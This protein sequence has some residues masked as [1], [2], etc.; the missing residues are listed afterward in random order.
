MKKIIVAALLS[1]LCWQQSMAQIGTWRNFLAYHDIQQIQAAGNELF[2]MA[3]NGLYQYSKKDQSI[4]TYDKVN[5][6]SSSYIVAI[7]WNQQAKRLVVVYDDSNIDLV[8]TNYNVVNISDIYAKS[9]TGG[10]QIYDITCYDNY[11]FLA[12]DFG[13]VKLNV[14]KAE[15]S[16]TYSLG[17]VVSDIAVENNVVYI[18]SASGEVF[19]GDM[20]KNLIDPSNWSTTTDHPSFDADMTDYNTNIDLV[21]TLKPGGPNHNMFGFMR[22][23]NN[24]LYTCDGTSSNNIP[25][26]VYSNNEWNI[27]QSEGISEATGVSFAGASCL[28]VDPSNDAHVFAGARNGLYEYL[29]GK[30]VKFYNNSNSPIQPFNGV[31]KE[32]QL[33]TNVKYDKAGNLWI[34]NSQAPTTSLVRYSNGTFTKLN[35]SEWMKLTDSSDKTGYTNKSNGELGNMI[36]DSQGFFWFTNNNW[37]LPALYLYD[38]QN[39]AARAYENFVNQ[40]GTKV[41][42]TYG[43]R[44]V[45]EDLD[46]NIWIGTDK[47]PL[48]LER[49]RINNNESVFTQVKVPRNDGTDLADYLLSGI[50]ILSMAIDGAGRKWFGTNGNGVYLLSSD[51]LTQIH[52]F[53]TENSN[54]LSNIVKSIAINP[55]SGEVFM[56]TEDGLCSYMSDATE[57]NAEMTKDNVW[58]YPNPVSPDYSGPITIVG[59]TLNADVKILASNGALVYEGRSNGG[60]F[61]WNGCD[62]NGNR[63]ASGV[64]MVATATSSGE[65]GTVCKIAIVR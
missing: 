34:M 29:D 31:S 11:A 13:V 20:S 9:I 33:V 3:S 54:L 28:D 1:V 65:K 46:N 59:L 64:Y 55:V 47:G 24:K 36:I 39:N 48:M 60:M 38:A 57:A 23:Q 58:A 42:V 10:K 62:R 35:H 21:K 53:T 45:A 16:E 63:V 26:Q 32:Y 2:V 30:F 8:D 22:F 19:R 40:D 56:G 12:C 49:S 15:I 41:D 43:V 44:C 51:N 61:T 17:F 25:L 7:R 18:K 50:D 52:H 37:I 4:H 5:G 14:S 27:Y 6:L